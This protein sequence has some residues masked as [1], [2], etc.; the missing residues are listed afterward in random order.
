MHP[1]PQKSGSTTA[2]NLRLKSQLTK[3]QNRRPRITE[4]KNLE[5][6]E[7]R[8]PKTPP[9]ITI[10]QLYNLNSGDG[11]QNE[12]TEMFSSQHKGITQLNICMRMIM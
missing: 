8:Q 4:T 12:V 9:R 2:N 1:R 11:G 6:Q 7:Q 3:N 10:I 5:N